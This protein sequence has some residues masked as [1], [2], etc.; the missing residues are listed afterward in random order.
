MMA[1]RML[2]IWVIGTVIMIGLSA[3]VQAS[4]VATSETTAPSIEATSLPH[5]L[6]TPYAQE[7]AAG[8][9][10]GFDGDVVTIT[11]N[12]DVPDPR[13]AKVRPDQTLKV[14]NNTASPLTMSI[15][16]FKSALLAANS[17]SVDVPFGDYLLPGVHQLEV[18]PCCGAELWLVEK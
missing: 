6:A 18:L 8:I 4:N 1:R 13:C 14:V 12:V 5:V 3:C 11:L 2:M 15:G 9:C 7:P 16:P 10:A 17:Y